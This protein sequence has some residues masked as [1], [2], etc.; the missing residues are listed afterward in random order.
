[1]TLALVM[2]HMSLSSSGMFR[3]ITPLLDDS[4]RVVAPDRLGSGMYDHPQTPISLAQYGD[5]T[6]EALHQMGIDRTSRQ[7]APEIAH[8]LR[9]FL[10]RQPE[11]S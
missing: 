10:D 3:H 8:H 5:A 4:R 11:G 2:L 7:Q 1:M 6:V 9:T